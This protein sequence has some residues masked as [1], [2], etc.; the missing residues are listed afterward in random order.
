MNVPRTIGDR[1]EP[2]AQVQELSAV[3]LCD[4][5]CFGS[6]QSTTDKKD[7]RIK[8]KKEGGFFIIF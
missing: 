3:R 1:P 5:Y 6:L 7:E 4:S 2:P 8:R